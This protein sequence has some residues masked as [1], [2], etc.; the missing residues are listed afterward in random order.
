MKKIILATALFVTSGFAFA[1]V[2]NA[3][4]APKQNMLDEKISVIKLDDN[5]VMEIKFNKTLDTCYVRVCK[6]ISQDQGDGTSIEV[7]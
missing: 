5:T 3:S 7:K 6:T 2:G 4:E 1:N